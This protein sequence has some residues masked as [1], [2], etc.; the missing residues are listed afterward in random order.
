VEKDHEA[1]TYL[2]RDAILFATNSQTQPPPNLAFLEIADEFTFL[3]LKA[4]K[5]SILKFFQESFLESMKK[6]PITN[7]EWE[8]SL[9]LFKFFEKFL[10]IYRWKNFFI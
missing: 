6:N 5:I 3:M 10:A 4:E 9:T 2:H 8:P 1:I 7:K